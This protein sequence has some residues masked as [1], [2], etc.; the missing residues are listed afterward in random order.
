MEDH[1]QAVERV[2]ARMQHFYAN[3]KPFRVYHGSTNSTRH[4]EFD[5]DA[6][7]D[8]SS[9][10]KI[11]CINHARKTALVEPNVPMD[12]LVRE[13][14]KHG[15]LPPVV[16]EFPG[17]TVGGGFVGTAGESSS[18]KYGFFDRTVLSAQVVLADGTLVTTSQDENQELFDGLRGSFGTLGVLTMVEMQ[19][20]PLKHLVELTYHPT[21]SFEN[22]M[23]K[24]RYQMG[25][26]SNDYLDGV[27]F[28]KGFG[29]VV[30]G[31]LVD[32]NEASQNL[33]LR[34]FSRPWDEWFWIHAKKL[35]SKGIM[36]KEMVPVEDYLFRYDRGAFWMGMYAYQHFK[37]P[38]TWLTRLL[39]DYLM[40]TRIMYHALHASGYTDRYIIH[41][42]AFPAANAASFAEYLDSKFEMY[43]LWLC[44]LRADGRSS[45]GHARA[46]KGRVDGSAAKGPYEGAYINIGV[47]GPYPS[48]ET[49]FVGAN[50]EIEAKM[51]ELGGLKWLYSRVF[52]TEEEWWRVYD[53]PRYDGL[54]EKFNATSLPSIWDKVKD[55]GRKED[56]GK[57]LKAMLKKIVRGNL[58]LSGLYGVYKAV[59]GGDYMLKTK[60]T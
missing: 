21:F 53:K 13:S 56:S 46:F 16:M 24:L 38:F 11:L 31:R 57:G 17:I 34:R 27:L 6:I 35:A 48:N 28:S 47:W 42:I 30:T 19:L 23:G 3:K 43:P 9:L 59:R 5:R 36:S 15:L 26:E 58:F 45:M 60:E 20:I 10:N 14:R 8:V 41:D 44:P 4:A 51:H 37:V 1:S 52:Y 25:E 18:F 22:A 50:R 55:R 12:A 7:V 33:P 2:R 32:P 54:R 40:H 39:L 29:V 49:E